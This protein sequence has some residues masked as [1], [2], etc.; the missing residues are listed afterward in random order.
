MCYLIIWDFILK[1]TERLWAFCFALGY[2]ESYDLIYIFKI[3]LQLLERE[4][5]RGRS[6]SRKTNQGVAA[7]VQAKTM[8]VGQSSGNGDRKK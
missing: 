1:V 5:I 2:R 4:W 6:R 7:V 8:D 3:L